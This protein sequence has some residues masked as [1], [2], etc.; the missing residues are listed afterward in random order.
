MRADIITLTT[1]IY[2]HHSHTLLYYQLH[3]E[4]CLAFAIFLVLSTLIMLGPSHECC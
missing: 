2:Q 3:I 4:P 1:A